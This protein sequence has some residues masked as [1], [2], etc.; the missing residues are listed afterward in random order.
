MVELGKR[1]LLPFIFITIMA[2][3]I[4]FT[5]QIVFIPI[6][7]RVMREP[8]WRAKHDRDH[9]TRLVHWHHC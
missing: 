4:I 1:V 2:L 5:V 3:V 7:P 9:P 8:R 6:R